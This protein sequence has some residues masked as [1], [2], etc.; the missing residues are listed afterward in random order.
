VVTSNTVTPAGYNSA[1]AI[2][3]TG[4]S[5]SINGGAFVATAGTISPGQNVAVRLTASA[6]N[7]TATGA[8]LSIGGTAGTFTVMTQAATTDTTPNAFGFVAQSG[9]APNTA[10]TSNTITPAGY[11]AAAAISVSGGSYSID[12]GAFVTGPG[13]LS[14]GQSVALRVTASAAFSTATSATLTIGGTAGTFTV[15]TQAAAADGNPDPFGFTARTGIALN[16]AVTSNTITP[17]GFNIALP[18]SVSAGASYSIAGGAFVST[19]GTISPGQNVAVRLTTAGT[20][21]TSTTAT[22]TIG[23]MSGAFAVTTREAPRR[24]RRR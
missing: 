11:D 23:G 13:T 6:A 18:I 24:S 9:I 15:T 1:A 10:V 12:G 4:G 8:T 21:R 17:T 19:P 3:V 7:S 16:T 14:P 20:Y 22:L 2:S 5:Y